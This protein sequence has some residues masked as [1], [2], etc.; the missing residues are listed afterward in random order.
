M[1]GPEVLVDD[2]PV[3]DEQAGCLSERRLGH[4]ADAGDDSLHLD[5]Q[6]ACGRDFELRPPPLDVAH[7][8][9]GTHVDALVAIVADEEL[10][11]VGR[12]EA[13]ADTLVRKE[14]RDLAALERE[15][16]RDFR[17]DEAAAHHRQTTTRRTPACER[18]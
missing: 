16:R 18:Q 2:D 8:F 1:R 9:P 5:P 11:Q 3:V 6:T 15:C 10:R 4:D 7:P 17:A 13:R 14:H 12:K